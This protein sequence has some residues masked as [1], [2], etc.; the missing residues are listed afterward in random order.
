MSLRRFGEV[1]SRVLE[2]LPEELRAYL[3]NVVVDVEDEPAEEL[4]R[5]QGFT[6]E[7]IAEGE[8]LY[9][10]FAPLPLPDDEALE[11]TEVPH[12]IIIFKRP[13]EDDFTDPEELGKEIRKTV[14]HELGH[15]FGLNERDLER[16]GLE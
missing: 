16:L 1:V 2:A 3:E 4:L 7:E 8:S 10:L 6:A 9:G 13:L 5:Q 11:I 12:R 14:V 15:H